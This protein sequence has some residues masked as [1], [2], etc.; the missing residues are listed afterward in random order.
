MALHRIPR[1]ACHGRRRAAWPLGA[2]LAFLA[3]CGPGRAGDP[4]QDAGPAAAVRQAPAAPPAGAQPIDDG[5]DHWA[6]VAPRRPALPPVGA[7]A[8]PHPV[9]RFIDEALAREGL[10]PQPEADRATLLRRVTIDLVGIP[11][12]REALEAFL[13]DT[14]SDAYERAVDR[15][16]DSTA[17]AERWAR[18]WMDVWRYADW[19]GRRHVPDVWNSAPQIWRWRDWIVRSLERDTGYDEMVRCMLAADELHPGDREAGVATGFLVRN[20]YAL[21]PNDWMR[22]NVEHVGKAFLGLSTNCAHCHDHKFDPFT[23]EDYFRLRAFFEP[24]GLRQDRLPGEADPGPFQEYE[25]SALRKIQRLGTVTV[26]DKAAA[27]PT[28][29][30][31]DGDERN[32]D[33]ARGPVAPGV[34]AF[35]ARGGQ[36]P[37]VPVTLPPTAFNPA[38]DP[39]LAD[40]F[41]ADAAGAIAATARALAELPS[42]T[43]GAGVA[44]RSAAAAALGR[45]SAQGVALEARLAAERA[46]YSERPAAEALALAL[47]ATRAERAAREQGAIADRAAAEAALAAARTAPADDAGRGAAIAAAVKALDAAAAALEAARLAAA[48]PPDGAYTPLAKVYPA[49]ST[50][51]RAALARWITDRGNPL[52][53]RVAVNHVWMRHFHEPLVQS[54]FDFGR[55]GAAPTHPQLLDWLAVEFMEGGWRMKALHRLLVTSRAYRRTSDTGAEAAA[56]LDADPANRLL[57]RMH[58]GRMEAE[59]VRDALLGL[60]GLL[61]RTVGGME[62]ENGAALTTHRRSLYYCTQPESDGRSPFAAVFDCAD[63]CDGYRRPRT[64]IPQQ[65]LALSNSELAH[66]AAAALAA[67]I[68]AGLPEGDR[69]LPGPFAAAAIRQVLARPPRAGELEACLEWLGPDCRGPSGVSAPAD[70]AGVPAPADPAAR[71]AGLVRVLFNHPDFAAIR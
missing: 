47:E 36:P 43:D 41:R 37:I 54:V 12:D 31:T 10:A 32:R 24:L 23:Q 17:Y 57:W 15:L 22:A 55:A 6:F 7:S 53:A 16:L 40:A 13:A 8:S 66:A 65:A 67:R 44:A 70:P 62:L 42:G 68:V 58:A 51:R 14:A 39:A 9:D 69:D 27:A 35:L 5:S 63:P 61:D 34:P 11:P 25:Y 18:H 45:A 26:Y 29:L 2:I 4:G 60:S 56:A 1:V 38:L 71:R 28:W 3:A 64:I 19:H 50:G 52:A 20:W 21:N 30:Y 33:T 49:A 59:V 48:A 46:R